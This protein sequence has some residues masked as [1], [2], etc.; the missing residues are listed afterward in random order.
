VLRD[1]RSRDDD[2]RKR[3]R[4]VREEEELKDIPNLLVGVDDLGDGHNETNDEF[5][6]V[7]AGC[8]LCLGREHMDSQHWPNNSKQTSRL[9]SGKDDDTRNDFFALGRSHLLEHEVAVDDTEDVHLLPLVLVQ[10]LDLA[11]VGGRKTSVSAKM[12]VTYNDLHIK[13]CVCVDLGAELGVDE[14]G[15]PLLV[16]LLDLRE[17]LTERLVIEL[18]LEALKQVEVF[19]PV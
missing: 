18:L 10:P 9:T 19:E 17:R 12:K 3:N 13:E 5:G 14:V 4:V 8:G 11:G 7:I 1:V 6:G 16:F 2:L 15:E